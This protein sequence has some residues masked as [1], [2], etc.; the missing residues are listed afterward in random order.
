MAAIRPA[1]TDFSAGELDPALGGRVDLPILS[2][3]AEEMTNILPTQ[4]GVASKRGGLETLATLLGAARCIAWSINN[5]IDLLIVVYDLSIRVMAM[6]ADGSVVAMKDSLGNDIVITHLDGAAATV[7]TYAIADAKKIKYAQSL[8][9]ITLVCA[10]KYPA[11]YMK[12][13]AIA[14]DYT[15]L[16]LEYGIYSYSGNVA[17]NPGLNEEDETKPITADDFIDALRGLPADTDITA[18]NGSYIIVNGVSKPVT[19]VRRTGQ[20]VARWFELHGAADVAHGLD[21]TTQI[22]EPLAFGPDYHYKLFVGKVIDP[23]LTTCV[24][25]TTYTQLLEKL[26]DNFASGSK[27]YTGDQDGGGVVKN[28]WG[29]Y[30]ARVDTSKITVTYTEG[31]GTATVDVT[32]ESADVKANISFVNYATKVVGGIIPAWEILDNTI[33]WMEKNKR[34]ECSDDYRLN[35][36]RV[37]GAMRVEAGDEPSLS[38]WLEG[39]PDDREITRASQGFTGR[40]GVILTPFYS[41]GEYPCAVAYHQ[42]RLVLA[43]RNVVYMSKVNDYSN[44]C[45]FEEIEY[46]QTSLKPSSEWNDP[47]VPETR[48]DTSFTQQVGAS[49]AIK[50]ILATDENET[51]QSLVSSGD[52]IIA[53][54]TTE[55]VFPSDSSAI[56]PRVVMTSRFGSADMQARFALGA[57]ML[58]ARSARSVRAYSPSGETTDLTELASHIARA[59]IVGYDFRQDPSPE[60]YF[61]LADGTAIVLK[62]TASGV[63]WARV[64]TSSDGFIE[65]VC[66]IAAA[67]EDA[68]LFVVRRNGS[69]FLERLVTADDSVFP[70]ASSPGRAHLDSF[71]RLT[72]AGASLAGFTRFA[73]ET[74]RIHLLLADGEVRG[75]VAF[76]GAGAAATF[77]REGTDPATGLPYVPEAL[78]NVP[79]LVGRAFSTRLKTFRIDSSATEGLVKGGGPTHVR[80][81]RS[82]PFLLTYG[83]KDF[84]I[85]PPRDRVGAVQYPYSGAVRIENPAGDNVDQAL[86]FESRDGVP[87]SIQAIV[88]TYMVGEQG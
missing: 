6:R 68:V 77:T 49:S 2:H 7:D 9:E 39:E 85:A 84:P 47:L 50:L 76:S 44:F 43:S 79:C 88:T 4:A 63:A 86:T 12:M 71:S 27:F 23:V 13:N 53:T 1:F 81:F 72:I 59:G 20:I 69:Y 10:G 70:S 58:V 8:N 51:V 41:S 21:A 5:D 83:G 17:S 28:G 35:G 73:N 62:K 38:V 19:K 67:D 34:Y 57:A 78:Q 80:L 33:P 36:Q 52:L 54:A 64:R 25:A 65:S 74:V 55:W 30:H 61:A 3:G 22:G 82:G 24:S 46:T 18:A 40:I 31:A 56:N 48:T 87:L 26:E 75:T 32:P 45:Y 60:I 11:F 16:D 66:V 15:S 37:L 42:G 14:A 29:I